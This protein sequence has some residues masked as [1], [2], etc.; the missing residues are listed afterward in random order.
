MMAGVTTAQSDVRLVIDVFV[1]I[2]GLLV[3]WNVYA[4]SA[5][6]RK[7]AALLARSTT[8]RTIAICTAR[9]FAFNAVKMTLE[10]LPDAQGIPAHV[11]RHAPAVT[12]DSLVIDLEN[13]GACPAGTETNTVGVYFVRPG[14]GGDVPSFRLP[15][16]R[17]RFARQLGL[18]DA[19]PALPHRSVALWVLLAVAILF[20]A[21]LAWSS[22]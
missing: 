13:P 7:R 16:E 15:A 5:A 14:G 20:I 22:R 18:I 10:G 4:S 21:V 6:R 9:E 1:A 19:G 11:I 2:V 17:V 8:F 12:A 3:F